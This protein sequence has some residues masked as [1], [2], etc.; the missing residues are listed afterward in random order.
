MCGNI[1]H[2]TNDTSSFQSDATNCGACGVSCPGSTH[3]CQNG[4]CVSILGCDSGE[5]ATTYVWTGSLPVA[6]NVVCKPTI[7]VTD[8]FTA[9]KA[10]ITIDDLQHARRT[11]VTAVFGKTTNP[12]ASITLWATQG[13][14]LD[15]LDLVFDDNAS[16][17]YD[18]TTAGGAFLPSVGSFNSF[19]GVAAAGDWYV[20][21]SDAKAAADGTFKKWTLSLCSG[22][23]LVV[24]PDCCVR[25]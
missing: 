25:R 24:W 4:T 12:T 16:V 3:Q 22:M 15:F 1:C 7:T 18:G 21:V 13:S 11:D 8:N 19:A 9:T 2:L 5:G 23:G 14:G 20:E 10:Y 6:K 17:T